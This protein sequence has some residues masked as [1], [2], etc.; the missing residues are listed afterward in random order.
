MTKA[1]TDQGLSIEEYN[2]ILKAAAS[3]PVIRSRLLEDLSP[4]G[5][6]P[7]P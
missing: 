1:I 7:G 4:S 6:T 3:D 5:Q 2:S